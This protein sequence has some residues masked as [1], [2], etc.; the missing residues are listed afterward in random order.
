LSGST[1]FQGKHGHGLTS[2]FERDNGRFENI[3]GGV[4]E[5]FKLYQ[6]IEEKWLLKATT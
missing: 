4:L 6:G 5:E 2:T 1:R 3:A